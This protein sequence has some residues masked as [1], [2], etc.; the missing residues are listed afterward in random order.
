MGRKLPSDGRV[1]S[2]FS[3]L[4]L[5][6]SRSTPKIAAA[7]YVSVHRQIRPGGLDD[8][9]ENHWSRTYLKG[10]GPATHPIQEENRLGPSL[11]QALSDSPP[12]SQ[13]DLGPETP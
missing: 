9:I 10:R 12:R 13:G 1:V 8:Q 5:L 4:Y 2:C 3:D 7:N 11:G 6:G